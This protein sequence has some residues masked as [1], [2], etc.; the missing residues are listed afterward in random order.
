MKISIFA[1]VE[2]LTKPMSYQQFCQCLPFF[3]GAITYYLL[4]RSEKN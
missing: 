1:A 3:I 4:L 2:L